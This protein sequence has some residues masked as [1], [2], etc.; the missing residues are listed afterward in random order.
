MIG[1]LHLIRMMS[2]HF[3]FRGMF[4]VESSGGH[5]VRSFIRLGQWGQYFQVELGRRG[6]KHY[7][8]HI[9]V[10]MLQ[11]TRKKGNCASYQFR[12]DSPTTLKS[13][14]SHDPLRRF[15]QPRGVGA[16][17]PVVVKWQPWPSGCVWLLPVYV[18]PIHTIFVPSSTEPS[19][20]SR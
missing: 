12:D 19:A 5:I 16:D 8:H 3:H 13:D 18:G 1:I 11:S 9:I 14:F 17:V 2:W 7:P 6:Q 15:F 4:L 10:P 20:S